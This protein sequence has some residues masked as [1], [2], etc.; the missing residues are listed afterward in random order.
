MNVA[1]LVATV[2]AAAVL[3]ACGAPA[4]SALSSIGGAGA[5]SASPFGPQGAKP[6]RCGAIS[7]ASVSA[8]ATGDTE[9]RRGSRTKELAAGT[10]ERRYALE[11]S[12]R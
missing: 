7:T 4:K 10:S 3:C 6:A 12:I 8:L 1:R 11:R 2:G 9:A 5:P